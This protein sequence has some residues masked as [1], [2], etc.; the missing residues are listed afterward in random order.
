MKSILMAALA[1]TSLFAHPACAE[2]LKVFVE[3]ARPDFDQ[4]SNGSVITIQ[5]K[6]DSTAAFAH[7][8]TARVGETIKIRLGDKPIM[9]PII[10]EPIKAGTLMISGALSEDGAREMALEMIKDG[11]FLEIDGSDK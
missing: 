6:P 4:I 3:S 5:L 1:A 7:F 11:A 9:E 2:T 8:T 10:R